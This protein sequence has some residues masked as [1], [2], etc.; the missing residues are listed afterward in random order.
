[1]GKPAPG[2]IPE[3]NLMT[4]PETAGLTERAVRR[5]K[6]SRLKVRIAVSIA[7]ENPDK[8]FSSLWSGKRYRRKEGRHELIFGVR[9]IYSVL[10][11][12]LPH[13]ALKRLARILF[14]ED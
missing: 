9:M 12:A 4:L 14:S 11:P 5:E 7:P 6:R 2:K 10:I 8:L 13:E 1:L 3:K